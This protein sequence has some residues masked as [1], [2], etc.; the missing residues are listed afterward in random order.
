MKKS[1]RLILFLLSFISLFVISA[2]DAEVNGRAFGD[3]ELRRHYDQICLTLRFYAEHGQRFRFSRSQSMNRG[4]A[5]SLLD[6]MLCDENG[7]FSSHTQLE[8]GMGY[9]HCSSS[10]NQLRDYCDDNIGPSGFREHK[11]YT[12]PDVSDSDLSAIGDMLKEYAENYRRGGIFDEAEA[13][14][15]LRD[16]GFGN[17]FNGLTIGEPRSQAPESTPAPEPDEEIEDGEE[18]FVGM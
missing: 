16:F 6:R 10:N 15:Q 7:V 18:T 14:G 4:T 2:A 17:T 8:N 1:N 3:T 13:A 5:Q 12:L 11:P 9:P